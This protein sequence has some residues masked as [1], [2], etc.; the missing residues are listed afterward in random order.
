MDLEKIIGKRMWLK[1]QLYRVL[2]KSICI[3]EISRPTV[4]IASVDA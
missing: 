2:S 4:V 1:E 3:D